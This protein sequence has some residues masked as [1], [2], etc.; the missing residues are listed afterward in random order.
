MKHL[1]RK[2]LLRLH[3]YIPGK[4]VSELKRELGL[5]NIIKL[6]SN[7]NPLGPSKMALQA[8]SENL[9][10]INRYPDG[11]G[12]YLR[13]T[14]AKKLHISID[15]IIL[16][17][18]TDEIIEL[19]ARAFLNPSDE[20]LVSDT[21]FMRYRMAGQVMGCRIKTVPMSNF[22]H[23]LAAL[24]DAV[25]KR[26]KLIY[27]DNPCN[28]TGTYVKRGDVERFLSTVP[29]HVIIVFDEAYYEYV[30]KKDYSSTLSYIKE[31]KNIITLRTF[32][33]IYALAGLR[34]GYALADAELIGFINRIRPP[35]N[36]NMLAQKAAMASINDGKQVTRTQKL[37]NNQR[38][39]LYKCF[40]HLNLDF[41]PSVTNFI[42]LD[43]KYP[44]QEVFKQLLS[45][46]IIVRPMTGYNL[47]S[48]IRITIGLP[49]ENRRFIRALTDIIKSK[50][51]GYKI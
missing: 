21:S 7:E 5:N 40:K 24:K 8:L 23:D 39:Y 28:P 12:F 46:G 47:S 16:G 3:P 42:L 44:A 2:N 22:T 38:K 48:Y 25:S 11:S 43:V 4:P 36:T 41:V 14:I 31:K 18:G 34:I 1:L 50:K 30:S 20:L 45:A 35:F 10:E 51:R 9:H 29:S 33:K 15:N 37:I 6:A 32:S 49:Q 13:K 19:I 27:I 17:N 26:T